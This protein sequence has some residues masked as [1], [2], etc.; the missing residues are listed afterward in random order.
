M[1]A[2]LIPVTE[3]RAVLRLAPVVFLA[4]FLDQTASGGFVTVRGLPH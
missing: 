1:I 4:D 2:T 3:M